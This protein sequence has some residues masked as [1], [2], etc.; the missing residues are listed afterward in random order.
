MPSNIGYLPY[1]DASVCNL[2]S[3]VVSLVLFGCG[4]LFISEYTITEKLYVGR[5]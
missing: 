5:Y 1:Y 4:W 2:R 3:I